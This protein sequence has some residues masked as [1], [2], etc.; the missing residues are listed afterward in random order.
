MGDNT[1]MW[2][3]EIANCPSTNSEVTIT[4]EEITF[5]ATAIEIAECGGTGGIN[6]TDIA[7]GDGNYDISVTNSNNDILSEYSNN[8]SADTYIILIRDGGLC[9]GQQ[10]VTIDA[11]QNCDCVGVSILAIVT[12]TNANCD[13]TGTACLTITGGQA[14]YSVTDGSNTLSFAENTELCFENLSAADYTFDITDANGCMANTDAIISQN[15]ATI[16]I[17]TTATDA[18]CGA[19]NGSVCLTISGGTAPYTMT[20]GTT[21]GENEEFCLNELAGS[22][23]NFTI[24]D[25]NSCEGTAEAIVF[26]TGNNLSVEKVTLNTVCGS[27]TGEACFIISD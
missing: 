21:L 6:I 22:T 27:A 1:F 3:A 9:V 20:D 12:T 25:A 15:E 16:N 17:Q 5:T 14:P 19:S 10:T 4:V 24:T 11:P 26:E 23:Y 13:I 8:L 2:T 7:G 18:T